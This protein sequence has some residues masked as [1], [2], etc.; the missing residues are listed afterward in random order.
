MVDGGLEHCAKGQAEYCESNRNPT[1]SVLPIKCLSLPENVSPLEE[2]IAES[3]SQQ[4]TQRAATRDHGV[5]RTTLGQTGKH[6]LYVATNARRLDL[7]RCLSQYHECFTNA[8]RDASPTQQAEGGST[9][10]GRALCGLRC[11]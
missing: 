2:A 3:L 5:N 1:T 10:W 7:V 4:K 6:A 11:L 9:R 8:T